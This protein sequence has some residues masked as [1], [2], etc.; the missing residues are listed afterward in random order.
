MPNNEIENNEFAQMLEDSLN[1]KNDFRVGEKTEGTLI[2]IGKETSFISLSGATEAS[3]TTAELMDEEG[4]LKFEKGD[5]LEIYIASKKRSGVEV[6]LQIGKGE[7]STEL[8]RAAFEGGVP[9]EGTVR[10]ERKGGFRIDV[11]GINCFCPFSQIDIRTGSGAESYLNNSYQFKVIEY[12]ERGRNIVLSRK[13]LLLE[14]RKVAEDKLKEKLNIGDIVEGSVASIHNFGIF[15]N[16]DGIEA[17]VPK[18]EISWSR[19]TDMKNFKIGNCVKCKVIDI[20]WNANKITLSIKQLTEEPWSKI[21]SIEINSSIDGKV[22]NI[23]KSGAFVEIIE[24]V[25]GFLH[26]SRMSLLK[27][28]KKPED[29]VSIGSTVNVKVISIDN[30]SKK[31]GLELVTDEADPWSNISNDFK[32]SVQTGI[33]ENSRHNG[34]TLRLDNGLAGFIPAGEL[35]K[36]GDIQKEYPTGSEIKVGVKDMDASNRKLILSEKLAEKKE[37]QQDYNKFLE[38]NNTG[39][40]GSTLG[41]MFREQFD[42]L[43]KTVGK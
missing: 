33:V 40:S 10:E 12:K 5:T 31:I 23:I 6:T 37:E 26:I 2:Q 42:Q 20:D 1:E 43:N 15:I 22:T 21:D 16:L 29:I 36:S 7:M 3:I 24:G 13:E 30:D 28:V 35:F 17:L 4:N 32:N 41:N 8:L 11:S 14:S 9:V 39:S 34:I 25:E 27:K 18:S 38:N 19:M